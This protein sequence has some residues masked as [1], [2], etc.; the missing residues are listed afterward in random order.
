MKKKYLINKLSTKNIKKI[1]NSKG[2]IY[3]ILSN[4][5]KFFDGFGDCYLSEINPYQIKAWRFHKKT[6]QKLFIISGKCKVVVLLEKKFYQKYLTDKKNNIFIIPNK[7]WYGFKN[8][9][10]KKVRLL[11]ITNKAYS[12]KEILRK[13]KNEIDYDWKK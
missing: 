12:E 8:T 3:K 2:N 4:K 11:N 10:A 7:H 13:N 9:G 1:K 6:T 5:D